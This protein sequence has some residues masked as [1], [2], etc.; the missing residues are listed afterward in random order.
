VDGET[1]S[2]AAAKSI[3]VA[4]AAIVLVALIAVVYSLA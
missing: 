1:D 3:Y 4:L 2:A